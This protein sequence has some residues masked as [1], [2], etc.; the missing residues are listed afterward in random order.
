MPVE[1]LRVFS[2]NPSSSVSEMVPLN[3]IQ[4][5]C[6][7]LSPPWYDFA[8]QLHC[9]DTGFY[10]EMATWSVKRH[11]T[12]LV[13]LWFLLWSRETTWGCQGKPIK[14]CHQAP[15]LLGQQLQ[16]ESSALKK[17]IHFLSSRN[18]HDHLRSQQPSCF[19]WHT[20]VPEFSA[21][22]KN[23]TVFFFSL[24]PSLI[25]DFLMQLLFIDMWD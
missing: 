17:K 25:K 8:V 24:S 20:V 21:F 2:T 4:C 1:L 6:M 14:K 7:N 23:D 15:L 18:T 22:L 12:R 13:S 9:R 5:V 11:S 19:Y 10:F 16:L 3:T